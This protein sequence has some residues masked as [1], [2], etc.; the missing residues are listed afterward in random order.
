M[1]YPVLVLLVVYRLLHHV[2]TDAVTPWHGQLVTVW[3]VG[4]RTRLDVMPVDDA[5]LV[6]LKQLKGCVGRDGDAPFTLYHRHPQQE[7]PAAVVVTSSRNVLSDVWQF[8]R[9]V[10]CV[11]PCICEVL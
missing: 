3:R 5:K 4:G 9:H 2:V 1:R 8:P 10:P 7:S 11:Q 6:R